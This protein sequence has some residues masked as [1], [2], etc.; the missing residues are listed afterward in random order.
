MKVKQT[1]PTMACQGMVRKLKPIQNDN[2]FYYCLTEVTY[3]TL[4][5]KSHTLH[6]LDDS[7]QMT[8]LLGQFFL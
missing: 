4:G 6:T 3:V 5:L 7:L 2:F 1:R 8:T